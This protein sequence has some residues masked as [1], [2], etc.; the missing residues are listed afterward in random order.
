MFFHEQSR[1]HFHHAFPPGVFLTT[2][3]HLLYTI[4][5]APAFQRVPV[6]FL[7]PIYNVFQGNFHCIYL[8]LNMNAPEFFFVDKEAVWVYYDCCLGYSNDG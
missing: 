8:S 1:T 4:V 5:L 7:H 3:R 6:F 2:P